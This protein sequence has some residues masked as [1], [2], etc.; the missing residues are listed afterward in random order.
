MFSF[1][2]ISGD[3]K[4]VLDAPDKLVVTQSTAKKYFGADNPVGQT[5]KVGVKDFL[6]TGIAA[7]VPDNS[8]IQFDFVGAFTSLNASKTEK[9]N[10]ANYITYLLLKS[11]DQIKIVQSKIDNYSKTILKKEMELTGNAYSAF[12]LE[13][14]ASVHLNSSLDG[15]EPNGSMLYIYV[16]GAV[17]VLI[18]LIAWV[19][20]TN[21]ST[22]QSAGRGAE[23]GMRKVLGAGSKQIFY[24]FISESFCYIATVNCACYRVIC[25]APPLF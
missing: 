19:N 24:Q 5:V 21:L 13:R 17:A 1:P 9:W 4:K 23:V 25:I 7:D 22:A 16:L 14:L 12:H 3:P 2:L 6:I 15:F 20:Y 11:P 10:E 8:Q 18:L